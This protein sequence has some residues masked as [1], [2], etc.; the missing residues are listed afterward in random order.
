MDVMRTRAGRSPSR[1]VGR[2]QALHLG[3][4][5]GLGLLAPLRAVAQSEWPQKPIRL[6]V[7]F[8][9]GGSSD[10]LGRAIGRHLG[11]ALKQ[12]VIIEN[13]AGA[14]GLIGSQAVAKAAPDGYTLVVSGIASHVIAPVGA[15]Q[16]FDPLKDF[17]HI[18]LLAGPPLALVVNAELPARDFKAFVDYVAHKPEGLSWGSPGQGTH[19]HLVGELF[20]ASTGL[21]MVHVPYKGGAGAVS[22][23]VSNQISA[24]IMT[25]SSANAHVASGKLRLL[26]LTSPRRLPEFPEVPT[27]AELGYP[28]LTSTTWFGLSGPAGMAPA[29][30]ERLNHEVR[31]GLQTP[32]LKALLAAESMESADY[33]A[34][35][36]T[37]FVGSELARWTP[38]VRSLKAAAK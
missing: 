5:A 25:L 2:R 12:A 15:P 19:G 34:A 13:K 9:P 10:T 20:R 28:E 7:P 37:H 24:G 21:R 14:G 16:H 38:P 4:A 35:T 1:T 36:F 3:L 8:G 33:D 18:A 27:L 23:L 29:V 17:T 26:A 22:D 31:R 6:V 32:S 11:E 30:V